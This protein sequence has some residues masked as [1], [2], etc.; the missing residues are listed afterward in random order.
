MTKETFFHGR[1]PGIGGPFHEGMT[2]ATVDLF[3]PR[4][5]PVAEINWLPRANISLGKGIYKVEHDSQRN[6]YNPQPDKS[7]PRLDCYVF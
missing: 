1:N 2:E 3:H 5:D 4:V 6:G 7:P